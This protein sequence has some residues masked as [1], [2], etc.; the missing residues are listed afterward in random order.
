M[1]IPVLTAKILDTHGFVI[2]ARVNSAVEEDGESNNVRCS[3]RWGGWRESQNLTLLTGE[4]LL[5]LIPHY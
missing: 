1:Y 3:L 5:A 4:L 2:V